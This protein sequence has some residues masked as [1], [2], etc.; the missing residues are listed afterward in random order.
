MALHEVHIVQGV[1]ERYEEYTHIFDG[2]KLQIHYGEE[3]NNWIRA[4]LE[5]GH[6][7]IAEDR[8]DEA[9]GLMWM[10]M[11]SV[12]AG[13]PYL[14]LLGVRKD[15]RGKGVGRKLI[16]FFIAVYEKLGFERAFIAVNDFNPRARALYV[17]LGFQK[18]MQY[19]DAMDPSNSVYLLMRKS[20]SCSANG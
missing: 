13:M 18:M 1:P 14:N 19:P 8:N 20:R 2:S 15:Y 11:E 12:Y 10:Q 3:L 6:I 7:F 17:R 9:V 4:G 5:E 16:E